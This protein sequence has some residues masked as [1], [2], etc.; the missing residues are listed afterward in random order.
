VSYDVVIVGSGSAGCVIARRLVD[1]GARVLVLEAGG[2]DTN[3]EVA[4]A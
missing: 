2:E 3:P 1:S 4:E